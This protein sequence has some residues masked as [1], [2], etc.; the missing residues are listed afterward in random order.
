MSILIALCLVVAIPSF[1]ISVFLLLDI[2]NTYGVKLIKGNSYIIIVSLFLLSISLISLI[3]VLDYTNTLIENS[4]GD[5]TSIG[6][7]GDI[8]GGLLNPV[9]A[10][11][12]IIAASLAFYAQ[13]VAN[14]KIQEQFFEQQAV[15]HFY[16]M[17]ELH[18]ENVNEF[19]I[20]S[21]SSRDII[22]KE[23]HTHGN[24]DVTIKTVEAESFETTEYYT[25]GRR[26][27]ILMLN[28][29]HYCIQLCF[30][31]KERLE[32]I[33]EKE[34]LLMLAYRIFFWGSDSKH[35]YPPDLTT[36]QKTECGQIIFELNRA[37]RHQRSNEAKSISF[38]YPTNDNSNNTVN[39]RF[40]MLSGHSS[41]LAHYYRQLYQTAKHIHYTS[42][43]QSETFLDSD[44][45]DFRFKALRAQM[46][47]EEQLLLYYNYRY[48]FGGKW[49]YRYDNPERGSKEFRFL[50]KY[51]MIH[52]IPLYDTMHIKAENP[53]E[54]FNQYTKKYPNADLFEWS[55]N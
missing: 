16:K 8:I 55:G 24:F 31:T 1:I 13:Y 32:L 51:L 20:K 23:T 42:K 36:H 11:I 26:C 18:K 17:L 4:E 40:I 53:I 25:Y 33:L 27:F 5:Y 37:R 49:D 48:G 7:L 10:F 47:N 41:R 44:K 12:G 54:H 19:K 38:K 14:R 30:E 50:S 52:N 34:I 15:G 29:I 9:V 22:S 28:D 35:L 6:P 21:F 2:T 43:Y 45:I 39:S 46:T 3:F